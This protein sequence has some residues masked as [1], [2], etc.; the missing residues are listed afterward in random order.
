MI[1]IVVVLEGSMRSG[2]GGSLV[3]TWIVFWSQHHLR[4]HHLR[5]RGGSNDRRVSRDHEVAEKKQYWRGRE[6]L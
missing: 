2:D 1:D 6:V 4:Q 3:S 5:Q